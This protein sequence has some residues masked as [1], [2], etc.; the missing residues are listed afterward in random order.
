M[1]IVG[2]PLWIPLLVVL[3]LAVRGYQVWQAYKRKKQRGNIPELGSEETSTAKF[4]AELRPSMLSGLFNGTGRLRL[5]GGLQRNNAI[6]RMRSLAETLNPTV[7]HRPVGPRES[8]RLLVKGI[9]FNNKVTVFLHG[10]TTQATDNEQ[11]ILDVF[12]SIRVSPKIVD[13]S[14]DT[15]M[16]LGLPQKDGTADL[17]YLYI[18]GIAFGNIGTI[19]DASRNDELAATLTAA[20][21]TFDEDAAEKLRQT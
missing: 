13:V 21:V 4:R 20:D 11:I 10:P 7:I 12:A 16:H 18:D 9:T 17:P 6:D 19:L 1:S 5:G 15:D 3:F 2:L 14:S 8:A